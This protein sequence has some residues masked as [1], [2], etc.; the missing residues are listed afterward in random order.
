MQPRHATFMLAAK[1]WLQRIAVDDRVPCEGPNPF[2]FLLRHLRR[3][4]R[5]SCVS[6]AMLRRI[7]NG[8]P[9]KPSTRNFLHNK[10][11]ALPVRPSIR[12]QAKGGCLPEPSICG[13][14]EEEPVSCRIVTRKSALLCRRAELSGSTYNNYFVAK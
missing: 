2:R 8:G 3:R 4:A 9:L 11:Q 5:T 7:R 13:E 12:K 10:L 14:E 6:G 1:P